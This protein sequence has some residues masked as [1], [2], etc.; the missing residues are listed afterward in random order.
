MFVFHNDTIGGIDIDATPSVVAIPMILL[1]LGIGVMAS[2]LGAVTVSGAPE[3][4]ST[5]VG[6]LQNTAMNLGASFGTALAGAVLI[7]T[8][9]SGLVGGISQSST[10]NATVKAKA[11][12]ELSSN[13]SFVSD[14]ELKQD[15]AKTTLSSAEQQE[16]LA[17]NKQSRIK[18]LDTSLS[19][20]LLLEAL[21]LLFTGR[22]PK[23][24]LGERGRDRSTVSST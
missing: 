4:E 20:I 9:S 1:G 2:Q 22:L 7:A 14:S 11:T 15:L 12:T 3:S 13:V 17:I 5:D 18:A 21:A 19:V 16:I 23:R 10:I 6:G 24:A 8:L